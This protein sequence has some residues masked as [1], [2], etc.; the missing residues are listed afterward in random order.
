MK[1]IFVDT[2][3]FVALLMAEWPWRA[4]AFLDA[5]TADPSQGSSSNDSGR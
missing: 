5:V 2:G 1:G 4:V 3:G